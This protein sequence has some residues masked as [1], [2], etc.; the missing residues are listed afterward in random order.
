[1]TFSRFSPT[2]P[3]KIAKPLGVELAAHTVEIASASN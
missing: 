3:K 1:V 2:A